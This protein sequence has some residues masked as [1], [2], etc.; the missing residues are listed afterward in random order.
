[1]FGKNNFFSKYQDHGLEQDRSAWSRGQP[2]LAGDRDPAGR[3]PTHS[4]Y[5]R[6]DDARAHEISDVHPDRQTMK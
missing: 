5:L 4:H 6:R 3:A 1:M 2:A